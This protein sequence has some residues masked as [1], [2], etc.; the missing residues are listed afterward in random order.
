MSLGKGKRKK[1][2]VSGVDVV[3]ST[4]QCIIKKTEGV[5]RDSRTPLSW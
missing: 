3:K 1:V 2:Y 4:V 5:S